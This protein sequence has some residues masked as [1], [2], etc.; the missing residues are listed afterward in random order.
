LP[1]GKRPSFLAS[2][3]FAT[4]KPDTDAHRWCMRD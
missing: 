3:R 2:R 1:E 4:G